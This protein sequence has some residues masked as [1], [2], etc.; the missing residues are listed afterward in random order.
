[1]VR[2][3]CAMVLVAGVLLAGCGGKKPTEALQ[4]P[5]ILS[6]P[7][8]QIVKVD[9]IVAFSVSAVGDPAPAFQWMKAG[10]TLQEEFDSVYT[11]PAAV[12]ADSGDYWVVVSNAQGTAISDTARL[13]VYSCAIRPAADTVSLGDTISFT[14]SVHGIPSPAYQWVLDGF[15][16]PGARG[17]TYTKIGATTD[18]A[19]TYRLV[20]TNPV[21][22]IVSDPIELV[23]NP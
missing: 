13:N 12:F 6:Q 20:I 3:P 10:D 19:G 7:R 17:L 15:D 4:A 16:L 8:P 5:V 9:G 2:L 21:H 14:A 18:D 1:M 22:V 11:I 23:V